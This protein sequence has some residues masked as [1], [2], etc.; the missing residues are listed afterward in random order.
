MTE[1]TAKPRAK[2]V[3]SKKASSTTASKP[4]TSKAKA[5]TAA[6]KPVAKNSAAKITVGEPTAALLAEPKKTKTT[7]VKEE[8]VPG[9]KK[10][11]P[12]AKSAVATA[13]PATTQRIAAKPTPE[14]RYR[15]VETTAYFIAERHGFNGRSDDHWA[16][17]EREI[18]SKLDQSL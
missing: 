4:K 18:A 1:K 8:V 14:E 15:M 3:T 17:A 11:A 2:K 6:E 10:K 5:T 16:A 12:A 9:E 7:P 13:K